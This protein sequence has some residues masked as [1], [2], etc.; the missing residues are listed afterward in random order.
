MPSI[1]RETDEDGDYI[2]LRK[3]TLSWMGFFVKDLEE[4]QNS[5]PNRYWIEYGYG[6]EEMEHEQWLSKIH[7]DDRERAAS[8]KISSSATDRFRGHDRYRVRDSQG[9]Y[10][11]VLSAGAV[12]ERFPDGSP[13]RY[14][15]LDFDV[16]EIQELQEQLSQARET[17]EQRAS[18]AEVLRNA[19]AAIVSTLDKGNA[20]DRVIDELRRMMPISRTLVYEQKDRELRL[21]VEPELGGESGERAYLSIQDRELFEEG[22]GRE[23]LLDVMR[24]RGPDM[25]REPDRAANFWLV[26]PLIVRGEVMGVYAVGRADATPFVANEFR[27]VTAVADYLALALNNAQLYDEVGRLASTDGLSGLLTRRAFFTRAEALTAKV[28][29]DGTRLSCMLLDIDLFKDINDTYGHQKGDEVIR[30]VAEVLSVSVRANDT[31]GRYGGEEFCALL[32]GTAGDEARRVAQRVCDG[33]RRLALE[34]VPRSVTV[35]LGVAELAPGET[36]DGLIGRTDAALYRA[37]RAGRDR[38]EF[39][40]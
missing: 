16:T 30:Q 18:E 28:E 35:S 2:Y 39:D 24:R 1:P 32:P 5:F 21:A 3:S 9:R 8:L 12:D 33:V 22:V 25:F 31:V 37:K 14:V 19:A 29:S 40:G 17:A 10:H 34:S 15:G 23:V 7:P 26:A 13:K 36:L 6:L 27:V 11:W 20:I 38:V 4:P